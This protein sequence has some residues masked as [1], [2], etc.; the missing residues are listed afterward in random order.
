[1]TWGLRRCFYYRCFPCRHL[2]L[3]ARA[4]A[5]TSD[6][7]QKQLTVMDKIT[8]DTL[9]LITRE[10]EEMDAKSAGRSELEKTHS[11]ED[12]GALL[13][14]INHGKGLK[15]AQPSIPTRQSPA[16]SMQQQQQQQQNK[17]PAAIKTNIKAANQVHPYQR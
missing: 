13:A 4:N 10:R 2:S 9:K 8:K 14:A 17:A 3:E 5:T 16:P 12:T 15:A 7:Q 1:V 6:Q 11:V